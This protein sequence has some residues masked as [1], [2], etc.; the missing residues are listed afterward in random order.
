MSS[1]M[2]S[3]KGMK[4]GILKV[5]DNCK[6]SAQDEVITGNY[7]IKSIRILQYTMKSFLKIDKDNKR[8]TEIFEVADHRQ[9]VVTALRLH[10][11]TSC[12]SYHW[13]LNAQLSRL[14]FFHG[15]VPYPI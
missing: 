3:N 2:R 10:Q 8:K 13:N 11:N 4:A 12:M 5:A 14:G 7:V 9:V 1:R 15:N 6:Q